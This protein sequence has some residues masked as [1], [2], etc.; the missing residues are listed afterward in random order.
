MEKEIISFSANEQRLTRVGNL[1]HLSS[2][3]VSYVEARFELGENWDGFDSV[4]AMFFNASHCV[5]AV[6]NNGVCIVPFEVLA[7]RGNVRVNLVGSISEN[8]VLTDRLTSYPCLAIEVDGVSR[9]CGE[10]TQPITPSQFEQFVAMVHDEASE[11]LGMTATAETLPSGSQ[12]TA[13]YADG[14]LTFGIP[15]GIQG[16]RGEQGIQGIQGI[17]GEQGADGF[18]PIATVV[19]NGDTATITITDKNG[20]TTAQISDGTGGSGAV[21][22]VN[23]KVGAVVL[24]ASDVG[25]LPSSTIIPTVPTN[26]SAFT[27]DAGYLTS[28]PVQ[29]VNGMTGAVV[30]STATA[31]SAGLMSATDK[32]NLDTLVADYSSALTA[33][34]VI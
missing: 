13:S 18:S 3:P 27:N 24:T 8:D 2:N 7:D 32:D 14:V 33:L 22:S 11:V 28:A 23:G 26:V 20:T 19:K 34:G 30:I 25:A 10:E 21:E 1:L 17:Q 15:Q 5:G 31:S 12:A 4:R 29:S 6:L 9:V 16:E